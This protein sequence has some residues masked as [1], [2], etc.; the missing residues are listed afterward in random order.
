MSMFG[1]DIVQKSL[2]IPWEATECEVSKRLRSYQAS[3]PTERRDIL[4][5][6]TKFNTLANTYITTG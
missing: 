3:R 5:K 1:N 2:P 4:G 6:H